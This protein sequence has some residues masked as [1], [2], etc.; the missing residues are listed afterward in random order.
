MTVMKHAL[1]FIALF[2]FAGSAFPQAPQQRYRGHSRGAEKQEKRQEWFSKVKNETPGK[3]NEL[4]RWNAFTEA[5]AQSLRTATAPAANWQSHGPVNQAG[6]MI[7]FAFNPQNDQEIWAGAASGG[8]WRSPDGGTTWFP[9][10]DNLPSLAI[11]AIAVHP[12][13]SNVMLIGTGEGYVLSPWFQYGVGVLKSSDGGNTWAMTSLNLPD[14]AEF[15]CLNLLWDPVTPTR[16]Y[17]AT[18]YGFYVSNDGGDTWT[19]TLAGVCASAVLN[20][21][22]PSIVYVA[23]QEYGPSNG[24]IYRSVNG[25]M[26]WTQL[27]NGLPPSSQFGFTA[28][29]LCDAHPDVLYAGIAYSVYSPYIGTLLGVYKTSDGGNTWTLKPAPVYDF[30]CYTP[31]NDNICQGWYANVLKVSPVDTNKIYAGGIYIYVS[32]NGGLSWDFSD[33]SLSDPDSYMHPDHHQLVFEPNDPQTM[34]ALNDGGIYKSIDEGLS[35]TTRNEGLVTTQFY[36]IASA[37]TQPGL[38]AGGTQDN[39]T[40]YNHQHDTTGPWTQFEMG[41]G[42]ACN[43]DY[44]DANIWYM[45]ELYS[46][47]MKSTNGGASHVQINNGIQES[48]TFITPLVMHPTQ[49]NVLFTATDAQ[50]YRSTDAGANWIPVFSQGA[51]LY[52]A[53]DHV[54]PDLMYACTDPYY[55]TSELYRSLDGG[56]TWTQ[57]NSP[58]NK[59]TDIETDPNVR[60]V[61]YATRARFSAGVQVWKS[62]DSGATWTN[63]SNGLPGVPANCMAIDTFS[64]ANIYVGTDLGVYLSTDSGATWSAF[65][66][67]LPNV[68]V[69]DMHFYSRDTTLRAGTHGRG[70]WKT[71]AYVREAPVAP[72]AYDGSCVSALDISPNP[73]SGSCSISY[74]LGTTCEVSVKIVNQLGQVVSDLYDGTQNAGEQTIGWNGKN[75]SGARV[76]SGIYYLR[77]VSG[78]VVQTRKVMV[79]E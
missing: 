56:D 45:T 53:F 4:A 22:N 43:I 44:T 29:T 77:V 58:G 19:P 24:G 60:G 76:A 62:A 38:M 57:I 39:G 64:S 23:L 37:Y 71:K 36:F 70:I 7:S 59:I 32:S 20:P 50:V 31:P 18:T 28:L 78:G 25:G 12:Q 14:S 65:N 69:H 51:I 73:F 17:L 48:T 3:N 66:E 74:M 15:A 1:L 34:Y 16:V 13:D 30:Y 40:W 54:N 33:Y 5:K 46:G 11:G 72:P 9:A 8:L 75:K 42:F 26:N 55:N 61:L 47:R 2:F 21:Q 79:K 41:D 49:N 52:F 68:V 67:N 63:I 10:T 6:R 35:W 27:T